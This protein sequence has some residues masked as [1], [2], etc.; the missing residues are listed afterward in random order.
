MESS[1]NT[2]AYGSTN[3]NPD[4][5]QQS[6]QQGPRAWQRLYATRRVLLAFACDTFAENSDLLLSALREQVQWL[7]S[8]RGIEQSGETFA[9]E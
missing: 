2:S 1:W 5:Y 9:L 7:R 4:Q 6:E 8:M 3:T